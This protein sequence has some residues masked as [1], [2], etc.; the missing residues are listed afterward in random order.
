MEG[1]PLVLVADDEPT[2]R[3]MVAHHLRT[4]TSPQLEV[5]VAAD[6]EEA[7]R[8]AREH[9][10]DLVV[11]D[12]VMPEMSGWEV[13]KKIRE[14]VALAH[15][16]VLMLTGIG[17]TVN[18]L[19]SPLYDVDAYIDKPFEFGE[20]DAKIKEALE[21]RK[22]LRESVPRAGESAVNGVIGLAKAAPRKKPKKKRAAAKRRAAPKKK[23]APARKKSKKPAKKAKKKRQR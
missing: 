16:G 2:M 20:L 21:K 10:P 8:M 14:D 3:E 6:G 19:T 15:T 18:E 9:L 17:H 22:K 5:I 11:L 23:R 12:V 4:L 7:L 1:N 13:A